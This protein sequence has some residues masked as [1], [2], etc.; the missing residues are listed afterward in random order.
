MGH[1]S[2]PL[3]CS[4]EWCAVGN[5]TESARGGVRTCRGGPGGRAAWHRTLEDHWA[6]FVALGGEA[7]ARV[8]R[9][10]LAGGGLAFTER[11]M[12]VDQTL[13]VRPTAEGGTDFPA[14]PADWYAPGGR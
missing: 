2:P 8:W 10:Y 6:E 13:A 9:L 7:T 3:S 11:R 14:T 4:D 1:R 12:G 5:L